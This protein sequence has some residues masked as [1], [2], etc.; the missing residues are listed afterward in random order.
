MTTYDKNNDKNHNNKDRNDKDHNDNHRND[1]EHDKNHRND[2]DHDKN[3]NKSDNGN[4]SEAASKLRSGDSSS[5]EK[6]DAA[7][8]MGKEGGHQSHG[9]G[10]KK[11]DDE[12]ED[13]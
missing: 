3:H 2:K 1:K 11:N 6:H 12:D 13:K 4:L 10:R 8:E 9:S 7:V 5:K